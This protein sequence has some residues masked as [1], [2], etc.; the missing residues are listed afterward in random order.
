MELCTLYLHACQVRVT[1]SDSGLCC[2][3]CRG[4]TSGGDYA[5]CIYTHARWE[6]GDSTISLSFC[7]CDVFRAII[8][9]L[10]C[11]F[12]TMQVSISKTHWLFSW[13]SCGLRRFWTRNGNYQ[14][15]R[16]NTSSALIRE[17]KNDD[18]YNDPVPFVL[19]S[20]QSLYTQ[21]RSTA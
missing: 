15:G 3:L 16:I 9:S 12:S 20:N 2:C 6:L 13:L 4:C 7:L 19:A 18:Q 11:W 21:P 8:N 17:Q 5:P 10:V 1:V 14:G